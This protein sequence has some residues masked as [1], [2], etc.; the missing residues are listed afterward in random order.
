MDH[1]RASMEI[2]SSG[3]KAQNVRVKAIA[4]NIA[5]ASTVP[6]SPESMPYQRNQVKFKSVLDKTLNAQL[7]TAT[8]QS[9]KGEEYRLV[10]E[11]SN[12]VADANGYVRM[13]KINTLLE[14]ADLKEAQVSR[15]ANLTAFEMARDMV[16][17]EIDILR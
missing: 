15:E 10:Y 13:P 3:L 14:M 1:L 8:K 7:I 2:A 5:N 4:E 16:K 12:P 9:G 6:S 17:R 11:P